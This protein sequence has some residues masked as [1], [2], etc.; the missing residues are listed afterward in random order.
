[1]PV[2]FAYTL[3]VLL[4]A[5]AFPGIRVGLTH[6]DPTHLSLLRLLIAAIFLFLFAI[7][8]KIPLPKKQDLLAIFLLGFLGFALYHTA[9][10]IGEQTI[11]A[12]A[13]SLLVSTTPIF[14]AIFAALFFQERI[15]R[16]G[17]FGMCFALFGVSLLVLRGVDE[18]ALSYGALIILIGAFGESLYFV[19]QQRY[20]QTYGF[21]PL[22]IY[23]IIAGTIPMLFFLPGLSQAFFTAPTSVNLTVFYLGLFPSIIPYFCLAYAI[24]RTGA[25]EATSVLFLTP[26]FTIFIAWLWLQE[27]PT[28]IQFLGGFIVLVG[29]GLVIIK[30]Q[31]TF[32]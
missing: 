3:A 32:K 4:W 28:M 26:V 19:F 14:S 18:L 30:K 13:A 11:E 25:S 24:A 23:T 15:G 17:W 29:V 8:K 9:L 10:S 2:V 12:G 5:S 1:M 6:Y 7:V 20:L 21:L 27:L 31:H 22:T 16:R